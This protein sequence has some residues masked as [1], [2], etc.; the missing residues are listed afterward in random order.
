MLKSISLETQSPRMQPLAR[1]PVFFALEG[2][3][4]VVVGGTASAAWKVE[5]LSAAGATVDVFAP[6]PSNELHEI[7]IRPPRGPVTIHA[8]DLL[9]AD[10]SGATLVVAACENDIAAA[11]IA[12]QARAAG[13]PINVID[14]P[15]FCD[16]AFG[17]IVNRSPLVIGISTD[18]AAPV[19]A[20]TIRAKL[21]AL[22]PLGFARWAETARRWRPRVQA[23][24]LSFL[25]RRR[26]WEKF[27]REAVLNPDRAPTTTDREVWLAGAHHA[28]GALIIVV[29]PSDDPEMLTLRAVRELQSADV[30][31]AD[32]TVPSAVLDFARREA[33]KLV[34]G[35]EHAPQSP[36]AIDT[37]MI[38]LAKQDKRVVRLIGGTP[39]L[40]A[41]MIPKKPALGLRP[42][43]GYRFSE[44]IMPHQKAVNAAIATC[45]RNGIPVDLV[46]GIGQVAEKP[47]AIGNSKSAR[48]RRPAA[49]GR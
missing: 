36:A 23:L 12:A 28:S 10:L 31:V 4:A 42:E 48:P 30:I 34:I 9:A 21:E 35:A 41:G 24:G 38:A 32:P 33:R 7:A 14:K 44:K 26:F 20:Q 49:T 39:R 6:E 18:G 45:Q 15:A 43:G 16:F 47:A 17:A 29:V 3:R 25:D 40:A 46:P 5:L 37:L 27:T 19:F 22:L 11:E 2:K 1:L 13:V 8:R